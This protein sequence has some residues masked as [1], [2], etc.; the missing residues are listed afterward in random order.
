MSKQQADIENSKNGNLTGTS[1]VNTSR[2]NKPFYVR[3]TANGKQAHLLHSAKNNNI[4]IPG[5]R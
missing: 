3:S 2:H 5:K 1:S 4:K